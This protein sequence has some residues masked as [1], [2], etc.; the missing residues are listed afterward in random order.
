MPASVSHNVML[1]FAQAG[2][3]RLAVLQHLTVHR[4]SE[5][6]GGTLEDCTDSV[7]VLRC[8]E[9]ARWKIQVSAS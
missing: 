5:R 9:A 4:S 2:L 3:L 8:S 1:A 7:A 6:L